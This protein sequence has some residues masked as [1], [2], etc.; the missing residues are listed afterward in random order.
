MRLLSI[1][2]LL[3]QT[4][5]L[6]ANEI[7]YLLN[8]PNL[9]IYKLNNANW[10][11]YLSS[12]KNFKIG[13]NNNITCDKT[14]KE[15]LKKNFPLIKKNLEIYKSE[16]LKKINLR[17][18]VL[19]EN[20]FISKINTAGI[21]DHEKRTLIL[22][23]NFN[24]KY[25]ERVI[26]HEVFHLV[27]D[28]YKKIF[29]EDIWSSFNNEEFQYAKCSTCSDRLELDLYDETIGFLTEYSKSIPS[30]DMAEVYSFLMT[31]KINIKNKSKKDSIL[32]NKVKFIEYGINKIKNF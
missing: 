7:N 10:L 18:I 12:K 5:S 1:L 30:E 8:I 31:N 32:S 29:D 25:F 3:L 16:F 9:E 22:D 2:L 24:K 28:S 26:H 4:N 11:K 19:C 14:S 6:N 21:P 15:S 23:L 13:I 17:F 20:L 27:H